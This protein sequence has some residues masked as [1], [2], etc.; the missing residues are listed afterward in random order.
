MTNVV[1]LDCVLFTDKPTGFDKTPQELVKSL[2]VHV[3]SLLLEFVHLV[4]KKLVSDSFVIH[5]SSVNDAELGQSLRRKAGHIVVK[6]GQDLFDQGLLQ[7]FHW[8]Q[9]IKYLNQVVRLNH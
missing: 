5:L 3:F 1:P 8:Q 4:V 7:L 9:D 6:V 2:F